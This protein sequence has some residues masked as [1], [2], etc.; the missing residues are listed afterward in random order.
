MHFL[1]DAFQ[2]TARTVGHL[3]AVACADEDL[4]GRLTLLFV[5][6]CCGSR[7]TYSTPYYACVLVHI[8]IVIC[9]FAGNAAHEFPFL[10][11]ALAC[12]HLLL[13]TFVTRRRTEESALEKTRGMVTL[14]EDISCS[15]L[16]C[17]CD[18]VVRLSAD[19]DILEDSPSLT[20]LLSRRASS[21]RSFLDMVNLGDRDK[22]VDFIKSFSSS[23]NE[24]GSTLPDA[25]NVDGLQLRSVDVYLDDMMNIPVEVHVF[26]SR[27]ETL[28][29]KPVYLVGIMEREPYKLSQKRARAGRAGSL[30]RG[31]LLGRVNQTALAEVLRQS[32]SCGAVSPA[33]GPV[34]SHGPRRRGS[35]RVS[36][37]ESLTGARAWTQRA[38]PSV[39]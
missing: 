2:H 23:H 34:I 18:A 4:F 25:D 35:P 27:L 1:S 22:Y 28:D 37:W 12:S 31:Q 39:G 20:T 17:F 21:G 24:N 8:S 32:S 30:A 3:S 26:H 7:L 6:P 38:A 14:A 36:S 10:L 19:L 9:R 29:E 16:S 13:E 11:S 5:G 15:V 33:R